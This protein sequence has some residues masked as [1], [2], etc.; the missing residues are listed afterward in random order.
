MATS[1]DVAAL[2]GVS[3]S[4]VSYVMSGTRAISTD[5]K[6]RVLA[7]MEQLDYHPNAG[8]RALASRRT[9]VIGLVVPFDQTTQMAGLLPFIETV[10]QSARARDYDVVLI[11][12]DEGPAGLQRLAGRSIVDAIVLMD[13]RREDDRL[14]VARQLSMP[15]VLIGVPQDP[16]GLDCVDFDTDLAG[17]LAVRELAETG[18]RTVVLV[19][20]D[21]AVRE[22]DYGFIA[23]FESAVIS[24]ALKVGLEI[25][26]YVPADVGWA[27][28]TELG[29]TVSRQLPSRTGVIG[30]TPQAIER[31]LQMLTI[32][33]LQPGR[34]VSVIGLCTDAT[35][36]DFRVPVTNVSPEPWEVSRLA[37][38]TVFSK[39]EDGRQPTQVQL[40]RPRL[41]RRGTTITAQ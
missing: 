10:T 9:S 18:H 22:R 7:A 13:I 19:A 1:A 23:T 24:E 32:E 38:N 41:T 11:T 31:I 29:P 28:L 3:Q 16:D 40:V 36:N 37:M 15:V 27:G 39:L 4:T 2:A 14:P 26:E 6:S 30:R 5:T 35:A 33:G 21:P 34:D 8:A 20:E 12:G 17:R 25:V